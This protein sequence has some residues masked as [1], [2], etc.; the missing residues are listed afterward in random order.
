MDKIPL[1]LARFK[2][3][4]VRSNDPDYVVRTEFND[5]RRHTQL[6]VEL[7]TNTLR[8]VA[9]STHLLAPLHA[10]SNPD[11]LEVKRFETPSGRQTYCDYHWDT[12]NGLRVEMCKRFAR[13]PITV[14]VVDT[15]ENRWSTVSSEGGLEY[16]VI[17][18]QRLVDVLTADTPDGLL[19]GFLVFYHAIAQLFQLW[20]SYNLWPFLYI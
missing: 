19:F 18:E 11:T 3:K 10:I 1:Y 12:L 15:H 2:V 14:I 5:N 6:L 7:F 9:T 17:L 4:I 16:T 8:T 20:V 13:T